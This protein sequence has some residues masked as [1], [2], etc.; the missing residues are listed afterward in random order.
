MRRFPRHM[1]FCL[2]DVCMHRA[3]TSV[4]HVAYLH[5][6]GGCSFFCE[7]RHMTPLKVPGSRHIVSSVTRW[8]SL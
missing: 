6:D 8:E 7:L 2:T 5:H 3:N 4:S 1:K